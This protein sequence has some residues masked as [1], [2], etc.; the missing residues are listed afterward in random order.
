MALKIKKLT[1]WN[2]SHQRFFIQQ[3]NTKNDLKNLSPDR[4]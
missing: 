1:V 4:N 3:A 2:L